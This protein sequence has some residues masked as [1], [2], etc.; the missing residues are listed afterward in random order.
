MGQK[1]SVIFQLDEKLIKTPLQQDF[2]ILL[3][4]SRECFRTDPTISQP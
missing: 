1:I 2:K 3:D 4:F